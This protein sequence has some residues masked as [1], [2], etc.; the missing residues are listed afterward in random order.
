MLNQI[1]KMIGILIMI[2]RSQLPVEYLTEK[3]FK[4]DEYS[5]PTA[6]S[7]GL[8]LQRPA[9][10][11]YAYDAKVKVTGGIPDRPPISD[12]FLAEP[13][14]SR[15]DAF[16]EERIYKQIGDAE[17]STASAY[18]WCSRLWN[19]SAIIQHEMEEKI[20][21]K[22]FKAE[23]AAQETLTTTAIEVDPVPPTAVAAPT[24]YVK[25]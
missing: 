12:L 11:A 10:D 19:N 8:L 17:V 21:R 18:H 4:Y 15:V 7:L 14:R 2:A 6:P 9:Y 24:T 22:N 3:A 5:V 1:R 23:E 25:Q 20:A 13:N 16:R